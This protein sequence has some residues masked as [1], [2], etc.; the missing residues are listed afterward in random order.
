[1]GLGATR[2]T[3]AR[4]EAVLARAPRAGRHAD[5]P[6]TVRWEST[7]GLRM[8]STHPNGRSVESDMPALLGGSDDAVT[9][10]WL[11]RAG[12]ASCA[13]TSIAMTAAA[14]GIALTEIE[15]RAESTSD[16]RG[17]LGMHGTDGRQV[18]AS[19]TGLALQVR[20]RA[21]GAAPDCLRALVHDGLSRS[22]IPACVRKGSPIDVVVDAGD[23]EGDV[24]PS[25]AGT[26]AL[27]RAELG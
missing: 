13:A 15:V 18:D 1:M 2:E 22:P 19:P 27:R 17:L 8:V 24:P 5:A 23:T 4:L 16:T 25:S 20:L 3:L 6:A 9:P 12:L 21:D 11:F 26:A 14:K 7:S 10:G